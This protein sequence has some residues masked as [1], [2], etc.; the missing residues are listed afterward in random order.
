MD[1][2]EVRS[3]LGGKALREM[4]EAAREWTHQALRFY[5]PHPKQ[6]EF[7]QMGQRARFRLLMAGNQVG[8]SLAGSAETAMHATGIYPSDWKGK[9]YPKPIRSWVGGVTTLTTRDVIQGKLLGPPGELG[10]GFIPKDLIVKV[11]PSRGIPGA[12][13]Y[14]IVRHR[15][16]GNSYIGFK[17]YEQGREKWQADTLDWIWWD[18][19]PPLDIYTEGI[20]RLTATRGCG[21]IT[22][23]PLLGM[24]Q[25]VRMFFPL[26]DSEEKGLVMMS[27]D[28][29]LHI[30]EDEREAIWR[31]YPPHER[32]ARTKGIPVLGS[33]RVYPVPESSIKEDPLEIPSHWPRIVG[34]DLGGG[35][36]P[37]AFVVMAHDRDLDVIH[38]IDAYRD[39]D[40]KISTHAASI[41]NRVGT[42]V[43][44]AWPR[45]AATRDRND[46]I[47][48]KDIYSKNGCMMLHQH[49]QFQDKSTSV[50]GGVEDILNRMIEGRFKVAYHL[51]P[52]WEEFRVYHRKDGLIVKQFDDLMDATR[53]G[54]MMIRYARSPRSKKFPEVVGMDYDPLGA[55]RIH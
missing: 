6:L 36:H 34:L 45:D 14:C 53:Y 4:A 16:G 15:S 42:N 19:E 38:V 12:A 26:P 18:E 28:D 31:R 40:P 46:G 44:V 32:E 27:L 8:K 30:P 55:G 49:A 7:H 33:G 43:P 37:T 48:Y 50:N 47:R 51:T 3:A 54:V 17:S 21:I 41:R 10:T 5:R 24:S 35:D 29:A 52:W 25:V 2:S 11:A 9:R 13:D 22:F 20:A 23:T 1:S 39:V